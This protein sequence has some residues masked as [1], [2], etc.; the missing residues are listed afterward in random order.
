MVFDDGLHGKSP[1]ELEVQHRMA[2]SPAVEKSRSDCNIFCL[3]N[4]P[5]NLFSLGLLNDGGIYYDNKN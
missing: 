2:C 3:S 4:S 1:R 5:S